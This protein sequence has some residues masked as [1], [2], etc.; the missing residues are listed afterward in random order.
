[1]SSVTVVQTCALP[2]S[3]IHK[4]HTHREKMFTR[5]G[6]FTDTRM[7]LTLWYNRH[8]DSVDV[9]EESV[10]VLQVWIVQRDSVHVLVLGWIVQSS[11]ACVYV[12]IVQRDISCSVCARG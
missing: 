1:E 3:H 8:C 4:S 9:H 2:I 10:L 7:G 12:W 6:E 11:C 5:S